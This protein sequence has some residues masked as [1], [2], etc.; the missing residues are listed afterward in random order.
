MCFKKGTTEDTKTVSLS[1]KKGI[2]LAAPL[3]IARATSYRKPLGSSVRMFCL[4]SQ[5][6]P[7]FSVEYFRECRS[8]ILNSLL[9]FDSLANSSMTASLFVR[10]LSLVS[11]PLSIDERLPIVTEKKQIPKM[12]HRMESIIS[13]F[14]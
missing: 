9:S 3:C 14:V 1:L 13:K 12:I 11:M 7:A 10:T 5:E 2:F 6:N 4:S 8:L